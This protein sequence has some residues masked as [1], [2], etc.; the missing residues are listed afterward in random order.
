[1]RYIRE[2]VIQSIIDDVYRR[3]SGLCLPRKFVDSV[4]KMPRTPFGIILSKLS[5]YALS[6]M[7]VD[8]FCISLAMFFD[9]PILFRWKIFLIMV[10]YVSDHC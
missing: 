9:E 1:M 4:P 7:H 5:G 10:Q 2:E 3:R 8:I 6:N